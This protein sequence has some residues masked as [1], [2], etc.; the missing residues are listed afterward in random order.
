MPVE[1]PSAGTPI[2]RLGGGLPLVGHAVQFRRDPVGLVQRGRDRYGD[3]FS[4][5]LFG[6][7]VHVLTGAAGNEAF[8]KAS[9]AVL[10]AKEAYQ[11]TVPIFGTG[12]AYDTTPEL[13]DLQLRMIHPAL[14]DEK[15]QSYARFIEA[16]VEACL[17]GWG[18]AGT[19]DLLTA[20][21]EIT[22]RTAGRCLIGAEFH[23]GL[24]STFARLYH[25]LEAGINMVAFFAPNFPLPAMRR[26]DRARRR[27]VALMSGLIAARRTGKQATDDFLDTLIAARS[28]DG[29]P[30]GDDTITGLLLTLLFAGQHTSAVLATWTGI[31]LLH[32]SQYLAPILSEQSAVFRGEGMTLSA[33]KLLTHLERC[34]KEA[35]RL[36]PPL[37]MLMRKALQDFPFAGHVMPAGDL[38]LVSPGVSHRI[39]EIFADP[40]RYDPERFAPPR[41]EDRRTPYG[42]IGFGG[43]KHRC[44]GLAFAYQQVKVIWSVLLR[45]YAF[46]LVD[47]DQR[48]NYA[49]FVVGPRQPCLVRYRSVVSGTRKTQLEAA[50]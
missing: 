27:V 40:M 38:V 19:L 26:R 25:D 15:M 37:V 48:P 9:D 10:S 22:I 1:S 6:R 3:I 16:E 39:G 11:F 4:F 18:D 46:E 45:R 44:I 7:T 8:F 30:L 29:E 13:M 33:L 5:L 2:P 24:A 35:E 36:H 14:R 28:A 43:G 21:S 49:T 47:R 20:M 34:I 41:E 12:V 42:L 23:T 50:E 31:L 32:N 17:D